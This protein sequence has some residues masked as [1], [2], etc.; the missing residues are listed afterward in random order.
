[1]EPI[2]DA[3][4]TEKK[5]HLTLKLARGEAITQPSLTEVQE[6]LPDKTAIIMYGNFDKAEAEAMVITKKQIYTEKIDHVAFSSAVFKKYPSYMKSWMVDEKEGWSKLEAFAASK[7]KQT[8]NESHFTN[9]IYRYTE[10]MWSI[11]AFREKESSKTYKKFVVIGQMVYDCLLSKI[12]SKLSNKINE[13]LIIPSGALR[14]LPF[15][16]IYYG[17]RKGTYLVQK[18]AIRYAHSATFLKLLRA[19]KYQTQSKQLLFIGGSTYTHLKY[20]GEK[21]KT[22]ADV[23]QIADKMEQGQFQEDSLWHVY[24]TLNYGH[25]PTGDLPNE[26]E[27]F[28]KLV[29]TDHIISGDDVSEHAVKKFS[30]SGEM[31]KFKIIHIFSRSEWMAGI[32]RL[33]AFVFRMFR[34]QHGPDDDFLTFSEITKLKIKADIAFLAGSNTSCGTRFLG[35][36][37]FSLKNAFFIAGANGVI[38]SLDTVGRREASNFSQRV[39]QL[40]QT[41]KIGYSKAMARIKRKYINGDYVKDDN[42]SIAPFFWAHYVLYGLDVTH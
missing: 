18:Y 32:P 39:H 16:A 15:E 2:Y 12:L 20:D 29:K 11:F 8:K 35:G 38:G 31:E 23:K 42:N 34:K 3:L 17:N 37:E 24:G 19:R 26:A 4:E 6:F 5:S 28:Q 30:Q 10:L 41:E 1:M 33:N 7:I 13:L 21:V 40:V 25:W 27:Q 36:D 14:F 9:A 22:Q